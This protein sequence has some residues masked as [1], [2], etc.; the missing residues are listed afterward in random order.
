MRITRIQKIAAV[1][2]AIALIGGASLSLPA[3]AA[4]PATRY[5]TVNSEGT[6]KVAPDAVRLNATISIV[7]ANSKS[8][9]AEASTASAAVR[10]A[11]KT[12]G[13][14]TKDIATQSLTV[15]PEYNY[16]QDKGQSLIGYRAAQSFVV[17]I[18]NA[19]NA[20]AIVDAVVAAGGD[21]LQVTGVT[22]FVLDTAKATLAAR[23]DAVKKAKAKATS[24]ALLLGVKLG[25][26]I[27]LTENSSPSN[28][29]PM[30]AMAKSADTGATEI[31]LGQQDVTVGISVQWALL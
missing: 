18:R 24:Y 2:I 31:D 14:D 9:L 13:V 20:G 6:V 26:V 23:T 19:K 16:T 5:I 10:A 28:Y 4:T 25:K 12:S 27:Y 30:L 3:N 29:A 17:T 8:A 22:P 7:G 15:F 1:S 21:S 11:L